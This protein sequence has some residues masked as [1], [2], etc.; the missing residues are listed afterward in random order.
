V[1]HQNLGV[2]YKEMG[3]IAES[4]DE[5]KKATRLSMR[6]QPQATGGR[7]RRG[8]FGSAA[9]AVV[10]LLGSLAALAVTGVR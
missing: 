8:C 1:A 3:R 9:A 4:V 10:V 6:R 7:A 2:V 5:L